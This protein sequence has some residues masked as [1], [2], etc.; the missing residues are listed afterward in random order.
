MQGSDSPASNESTQ[1]QVG[2]PLRLEEN[3]TSEDFRSLVVPEEEKSAWNDKVREAL[4]RFIN[5][6]YRDR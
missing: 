6:V 4:V 2:S 3:P 1:A 5:N